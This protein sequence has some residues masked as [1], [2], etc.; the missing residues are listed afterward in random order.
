MGALVLATEEEGNKL[1]C[2][3]VSGLRG[4]ALAETLPRAP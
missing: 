4:D 2:G 1:D 3:E